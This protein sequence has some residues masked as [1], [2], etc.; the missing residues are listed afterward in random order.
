[1]IENQELYKEH[2]K[3]YK[4][5]DRQGSMLPDDV[6]RN[7]RMLV[8]SVFFGVISY[9]FVTLFLLIS[10][11]SVLLMYADSDGSMSR[12][13]FNLMQIIALGYF[14]Q[15]TLIFI[16]RSKL[17]QNYFNLGIVRKFR[18]RLKIALIV[19][20]ITVGIPI[21]LTCIMLVVGVFSGIKAKT[22]EFHRET[23]INPGSSSY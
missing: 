23:V 21:I 14:V 6:N 2:K 17:K 3:D 19:T 18:K 9:L 12:N 4:I 11:T 7:N 20:S 10:I 8:L 15:G 1:M 13:M 22:Q 16:L 5:N